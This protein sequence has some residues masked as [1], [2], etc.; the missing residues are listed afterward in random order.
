MKD[1]IN[2]LGD[3][4]RQQLGEVVRF[5]IVGVTATL[6]QY[7]IYWLLLRLAIHWDVEAG[8]HTLSTVAMTIGYVVSFIYNFIASTRFT[9]R[10]KANARRGAGFLFSHVVNYSLQMLTLNLF[11]LLGISKQWAPIPMFC[12]CVPV[13]FLLVRFFLKR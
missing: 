13:N 1:I 5:G 10:V 12:V 7:F 8:T 11:L 4:R 3:K 9:F 6:L 2:H